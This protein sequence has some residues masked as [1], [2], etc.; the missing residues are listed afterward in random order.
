[1][2]FTECLVDSHEAYVEKAI[3]LAHDRSYRD[4]VKAQILE[5]CPVLFED[6]Q[7]V[8]DHVEF[9]RKAVAEARG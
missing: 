1:M 7:V 4:H 5:R 8:T 2:E 9:F 6:D 3:Q